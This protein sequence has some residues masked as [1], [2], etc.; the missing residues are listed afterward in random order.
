MLLS[1]PYSLFNNSKIKTW[2]VHTGDDEKE[3]FSVDISNKGYYHNCNSK[4]D[5]IYE[6]E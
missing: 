2:P 1:T 4:G 5:I 6:I 3:I